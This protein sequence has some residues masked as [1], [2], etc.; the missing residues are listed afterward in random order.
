MDF[1][2]NAGK[3]IAEMFSGQKV[4]GSFKNGKFVSDKKAI[5][6]SG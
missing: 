1:L 3:G 2:F 6:Q 4:P 5:P